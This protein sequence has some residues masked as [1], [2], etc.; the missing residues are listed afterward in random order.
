MTVLFWILA[1]GPR[2]LAV[3]IGTAPTAEIDSGLLVGRL[4]RSGGVFIRP[5]QAQPG[6]VDARPTKNC[7]LA[8][9]KEPVPGNCRSTAGGDVHFRNRKNAAVRLIRSSV[10]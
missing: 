9:L 10:F 2:P 3:L 6:V 8:I 7:E 5:G 1:V 4:Q